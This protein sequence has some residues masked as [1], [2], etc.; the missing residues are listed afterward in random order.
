VDLMNAIA[1]ATSIWESGEVE[2]E[3][4]RDLVATCQVHVPETY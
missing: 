3:R 1:C 2:E 4:L